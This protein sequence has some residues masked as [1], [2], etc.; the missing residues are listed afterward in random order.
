MNIS[1]FQKIIITPYCFGSIFTGIITAGVLL[2]KIIYLADI[3]STIL[4]LLVELTL[5]TYILFSLKRTERILNNG[6]TI[7]GSIDIIRPS[8]NSRR[9]VELSYSFQD[10]V[11]KRK[12][13]VS[14]GEMNEDQTVNLQLHYS[15]PNKFI[16]LP[17]T[18]E[19]PS[20]LEEYKHYNKSF[21]YV[22]I[23]GMLSFF[24]FI[25]YKLFKLL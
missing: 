1:I 7:K 6:Q 15:N 4:L 19:H 25:I 3:K 9:W 8:I 17:P 11:Y 21:Y 2:P 18:T 10:N 5:F 12:M 22:F 24:V 20:T 14:T 23:F 13:E 16:I